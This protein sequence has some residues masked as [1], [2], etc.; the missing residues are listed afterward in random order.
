MSLPLSCIITCHCLERYIAQCLQSAFCQDYDGLLQFI[1]VDDSSTDNSVSVIQEN[2]ELYAQGLD[3]TFIKN[4]TNMGVAAST[5]QAVS[6]A[7][8]RHIVLMDGDDFFPPDRCKSTAEIF[9]KH[10]DA[11]M[12]MGSMMR[13][14]A[15]GSP[16]G[17]QSYAML[18][19]YEDS[20]EET[21]LATGEER[22][23]D[24]QGKTGIRMNVYGAA[25]AFNK[26]LYDL[27]GPITTSRECP[28]RC[29]QDGVLDIRSLLAGKIVGSKKIMSYYRMHAAN[30]TN[31]EIKQS[32]HGRIAHELRWTRNQN[33][34]VETIDRNL[35]DMESALSEGYTDW[36][37]EDLT[38]LEKELI[39]KRR[40]H[41]F[42]SDW[43]DIP[44][45]SRCL[46]L[47]RAGL[48]ADTQ[49]LK[50]ALFRIF[51]LHVHVFLKG[52]L[53]VG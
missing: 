42:R 40:L 16:L 27:F 53:K 13:V 9:E 8:Y 50:W 37:R 1:I 14:D 33:M 32:H 3:C 45:R 5:D 29:S 2:M 25:M 48:D 22:W 21:V 47:L 31:G 36:S 38:L 51:P 19:S 46:R 39:Q 52:I 28:E 10:P 34:F 23:K 17:P 35:K 12:I 4:P 41:H 26:R 24:Y 6:M 49:N 15:E 11:L 43:W 44:Y 20:P 30:L 7:K 18:P